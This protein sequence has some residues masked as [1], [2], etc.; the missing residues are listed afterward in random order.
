MSGFEKEELQSRMQGMT[1]EEQELVVKTLP[2]EVI[3]GEM[4]RRYIN[5]RD[6]VNS[7]SQAVQRGS[8][9]E[10]YRTGVYAFQKET[11]KGSI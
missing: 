7:I 4:T 8:S 9:D 3:L 1:P 5:M 10:I 11:N 6:T 2:D